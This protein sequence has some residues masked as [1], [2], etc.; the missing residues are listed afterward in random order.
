MGIVDRRGKVIKLEELI[1]ASLAQTDALSK[2]LIEKGLI[3]EAE[4][5]G[6]A[7]SREGGVSGDVGKDQARNVKSEGDK[8]H[9]RNRFFLRNGL[10]KLYHSCLANGSLCHHHQP[11]YA[12]G[13]P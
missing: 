10:Y 12:Y 2:L 9:E 7:F 13:P 4:F 8:Y 11:R 3:T 6:E 5:Y 1:I